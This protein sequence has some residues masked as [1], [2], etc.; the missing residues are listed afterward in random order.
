V[1]PASARRSSR[2]PTKLASCAS[3]IA[4]SRG[5]RGSVAASA[6]SRAQSRPPTRSLKPVAPAGCSCAPGGRRPPRYSGYPKDA[7]T[8]VTS[9]E[10][11]VRRTCFE[12]LGSTT[13]SRS[14]LALDY[15]EFIDNHEV[16][17]ESS[18][19]I[20]R[21]SAT[22]RAADL[23]A[24]LKTCGGGRK[25]ATSAPAFD[26]SLI[27]AGLNHLSSPS[28]SGG[29]DAG[30]DG[31]SRRRLSTIAAATSAIF[32]R[33]RYTALYVGLRML[34]AEPVGGPAGWDRRGRGRPCGRPAQRRLRARVA[35]MPSVTAS[36]G[37]RTQ[38]W[39]TL[40][41]RLCSHALV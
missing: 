13:C 11:K 5:W 6:F 30:S 34:A 20:N 1:C 16:T 4:W 3:R 2:A 27:K 9:D 40:V 32:W 12:R 18:L 33:V 31:G 14:Y 38:G 19:R 7:L 17:T 41:N 10:Q 36:R 39:L 21:W 25:R 8:A 37:H 29:D 24:P 26:E 22:S 28:A 35:S 15:S 23:T